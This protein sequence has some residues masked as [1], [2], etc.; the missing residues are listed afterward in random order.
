MEAFHLLSRGGAK[1]DK[2]RFK[3]DI[4]LFAV[5][6]KVSWSWISSLQDRASG[7][8]HWSKN[9]LMQTGNY[10]R[11]SIS[12]NMHKV[13]RNLAKE[14]FRKLIITDMEQRSAE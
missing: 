8:V 5:S 6:V 10:L 3:N 2:R 1:F 7:V 12:S 11:H 9:Q 13:A 14:S 4:Q